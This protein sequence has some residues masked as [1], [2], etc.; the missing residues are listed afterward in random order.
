ML[1][2]FSRVMFLLLGYFIY[3]RFVDRLFGSDPSRKTP[4]E[5]MEDGVDYVK[6]PPWKIF[7]IQLLNIAGL[8]PIFGPILGALYGP[9]ALIWIVVGCIFGGAVH[10]YFSG[11]LSMRY[12]GESAC[13]EVENGARPRL[14]QR[15]AFGCVCC[16]LCLSPVLEHCLHC[17]RGWVPN[18]PKRQPP[19]DCETLSSQ[20]TPSQ[21]PKNSQCL[22]HRAI[23]AEQ[24]VA[25][26]QYLD[27]S[28][29]AFSPSPKP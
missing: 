18:Q 15:R 5:T 13:S 12:N 27:C 25:A 10:D 22:F 2:F 14:S 16:L 26:L 28:I 23:A 7:L 8:G 21:T 4:V 3:G 1:Y 17:H 20:K 11:M 6:M 24:L 29:S 9:V 19:S